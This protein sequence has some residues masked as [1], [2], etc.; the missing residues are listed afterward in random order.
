MERVV[1][2]GGVAVFLLGTTVTHGAVDAISR[3]VAAT[4]VAGS[5]IAVI[6]SVLFVGPVVLVIT[7]TVLLSGLAVL[8]WIWTPQSMSPT[9]ESPRP[10]R[11]S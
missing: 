11:E 10:R 7:V 5:A 8:E 9:R 4:W 3:T 2:G 6:A 1:L